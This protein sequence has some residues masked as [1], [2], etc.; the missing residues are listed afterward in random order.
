MSETTKIAFDEIPDNLQRPGH[1]L[2][3]KALYRA[4]VLLPYPSRGLVI[5]AKLAAGTATAGT[6]YSV[7]RRQ[8]ATALFGA[9][10]VAEAM[11]HFW[12]SANQ[13]VPLDVIG[14][15][16]LGG[17][18][19]TVHTVT[20]AGT[21]TQGGVVALGIGGKRY[22]VAMPSGSTAASVGAAMIAAIQAA[23][24]APVV[25][26]GAA[27][28]TLTAKNAGPHGT[29]LDVFQSPAVGDA[30]PPGITATVVQTTAGTGVA[31][32]SLALTAIA[33]V[34]Y[35]DI[36][37]PFQDATN[38]GL[39]TAEMDRRW[40]AMV[41]M[42]G[43]LY[44]VY[45]GSLAQQ[46]AKAVA[47]NA[48]FLYALGI[49]NPVTPPWAQAASMA[50]VAARELLNDPARQL[51]DLALPDVVG[52][53]PADRRTSTEEEQQLDG[54]LSSFRVLRDGGV[55]LQRVVS[56]YLVNAQAVPDPAYHDIMEQAVAA[57]I[58]RATNPSSLSLTGK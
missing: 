53:R 51:R 55:T 35:T 1:Y 48:R 57:R 24:Q 29:D 49:T 22:A 54:G 31:D 20:F 47:A 27:A 8:E 37:V 14:L 28:M 11:A 46:L 19:K 41:R 34:H 16:D 2:E 39:L 30:M 7:A 32:V 10:S 5:A 3:I 52:N 36:V 50:A 40:N 43:R 12:L 44:A 13:T 17:S 23:P 45:T 33:G 25:A 26:A 9:G 15:A 6:V 21:S 38:L 18:T 42:E 4:D 56:T 58:R